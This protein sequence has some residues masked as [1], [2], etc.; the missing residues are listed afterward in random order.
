MLEIYL[1]N[2]TKSKQNIETEKINYNLKWI[3]Y[4]AKIVADKWDVYV[5]MYSLDK[6]N[7]TSA[8]CYT[9]RLC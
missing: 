4:R 2:S 1:P 8:D 7:L 3:T 5:I 6:L 9:Q